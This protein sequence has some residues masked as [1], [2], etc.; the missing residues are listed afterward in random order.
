MPLK[1]DAVI[2]KQCKKELK[3]QQ[4]SQVADRRA[5]YH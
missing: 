3:G 2:K 5:M 4:N 1:K